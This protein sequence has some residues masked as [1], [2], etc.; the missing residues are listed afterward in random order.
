M[1]IELMALDDLKPYERNPRDNDKAV[2]AVAESI[3]QYGWQQPIVVDENREIVVGHTR[4]KAAQKL[5]MR[6]APVV[7]ARDLT[8]EQ[9]K[10]YRLADNKTGEKATWDAKLLKLEIEDLQALDA[11][12]IPGFTK[13]DIA[14]IVHVDEMPNA[15]DART[16]ENPPEFFH[17]VA[18]CGNE[19]E[20]AEVIKLLMDHGHECRA[21][22]S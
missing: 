1:Q 12:E 14:R 2:D 15:G 16:D 8:E 22:M 7:V 20:Q 19:Q 21:M 6:E 5:G 10:A 18:E 4:Y 17:V 9:I 13:Y 11:G 3:K